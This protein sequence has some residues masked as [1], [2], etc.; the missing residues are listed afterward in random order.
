MPH[1]PLTLVVACLLVGTYIAPSIPHALSVPMLVGAITVGY[2]LRLHRQGGSA[3]LLCLAGLMAGTLLQS[4]FQQEI[5]RRI[6][7]P[8][9]R[10]VRGIVLRGCTLKDDRHQCVLQEQQQQSLLWLSV[11][12]DCAARPGDELVV[13]A[14][15]TPLFPTVNEGLVGPNGAMLRRNI[16]ATARGEHCEIVGRSLSPWLALRRAALSLRELLEHGIEQSFERENALRARSLL[17]GDDDGI[18]DAVL[19]DFRRSGLSHLLAV[20]GAHVALLAVVL[21]WFARM[22]LRRFRSLL[23]RGWARALEV[24]LPL[25]ML[26]AFVMATGEAPS[27]VR[28]LVMAL[29]TALASV[30]GRKPKVQA[31]LASSVVITLLLEPNWRFDVGW[32][33][34]IAASW[35]LV[36]AHRA[37]VIEE[38]SPAKNGTLRV[39]LTKIAQSLVPT[40]RVALLTLPIVARMS[41]EVPVGALCANVIAAP[42][43][44]AALLPGVLAVSFLSLVHAGLAAL[45]GK[46]IGLGLSLLFMIPGWAV[47]VPLASV[48]VLSPTDGQA[49]GWLLCVSVALWVSPQNRWRIGFVFVAI[50]AVVALEVRHRAWCHPVG[51]LRLTVIDVGQGDA[52]LVDLPDGTAMLIDAGGVVTGADPGARVV[53]PFLAHRRRRD[54]AVVAASHPHPDHVNGLSAVFQWAHIGEFWD[55]RQSEIVPELS[56][57]M[58][59]RDEASRR[60]GW[61]IRGPESLCGSASLLPRTGARARILWPCPQVLPNT[62]PND[63]SFVLRLDYGAGSLLL[64]GDLERDGEHALLSVLEPVTVLK[65]GH[66][67]S[68][69]SS[70]EPWLARLRPKVGVVSAGHPSPFHHPHA[71]VVDRFARLAIALWDTSTY[72][73]LR[74][75]VHFDGR[76]EVETDA[77]R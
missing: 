57:W 10:L 27:A 21:Q 67:G 50:V 6:E 22:V 30:T 26:T 8:E 59:T 23:A 24:A 13:V 20:S 47:K 48:A 62:P 18:S 45:L 49:F 7:Y 70:S 71:Q 74:I 42:F 66:H 56:R 75:T 77:S 1:T 68:R 58:N 40:F 33:L 39:V 53:V 36:S 2:Y 31:V 41:G 32:Q 28:A 52:L 11:H 3:L 76:Y 73:T 16:V 17:F 72:G 19:Q 64:P 12:R 65:L 35:G 55:T 29:V 14:T 43:A 61:P 15:V 69:T 5:P 9:V 60:Y 34:S 44:E 25:P 38:D 46:L 4:P 54:L 37:K 51:V 63:A